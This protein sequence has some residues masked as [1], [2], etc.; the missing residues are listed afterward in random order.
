[1]SKK[2]LSIYDLKKSLK[3]SDS[4]IPHC[5]DIEKLFNFSNKY[6]LKKKTNENNITKNYLKI[7]KK[8]IFH[9]LC[10]ELNKIHNVNY[11]HKYWEIILNP[12]LLLFLDKTFD[13]FKRL[14]KY[15]S[16]NNRKY[17][18]YDYFDKKK[19]IPTN[20]E[21]LQQQTYDTKE[22][23]YQINLELI[24]S[25]YSNRIDCKIKKETKFD[26][27]IKDYYENRSNTYYYK[28]NFNYLLG[29]KNKIVFFKGHFGR[30]NIIILNLK[31]HQLPNYFTIDYKKEI[32]NLNK[33][34]NNSIL[35]FEV[36]NKYEKYLSKN[37][38]THLPT[39]LLEQFNY[40]NNSYHQIMP[41]NP[42]LIF[43]TNNLWW[44][45]LLMFY[46]A[47]MK[48][49][50]KTKLF[51]YQHGFSYGIYESLYTDHEYNISDVF[52]TWGWKNNKK[53]QKLGVN[54]IFSRGKNANK[55]LFV[56]RTNKRFPMN[57]EYNFDE[58]DWIKYIKQLIKIP[59][60]INE[61]LR[62][63]IIYRVHSGNLCNEFQFLKKRINNIEFSDI[64]KPI[65]KSIKESKIVVCTFLDTVF[66]QCLA[67][68]I[69]VLS[70]FNF[71]KFNI[72][73]KNKLMLKNLK[74][75]NVI[76][77]NYENL[78]NH[79]NSKF[80]HIE[81]WWFSDKIQRAIL[82]F[83]NNHAYYEK[84]KNSKIIKSIKYILKN[85]QTKSK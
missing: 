45:T 48:F 2:F 43:N 54:R 26:N 85:D 66:L 37:L 64:N 50:K 60:L 80:D 55:I 42:K 65:D 73:N 78:C 67:S 1:M 14:N 30:K 47:N 27:L 23:D 53:N 18:T 25:L 15:L 71:K 32:I 13:K 76:F 51:T 16:L 83:K 5:Y 8:K 77:D 33:I 49:K 75:H 19:I 61:E 63:N 10:K 34:R 39:F 20:Y 74:K 11:G 81:E 82:K 35:N 3:N 70:F 52:F 7:L 38:F 29:K 40:Y 21:S 69:P 84:K 59:N 22:W 56:H 6:L 36:K 46:T 31:C 79:I 24:K 28:K 12:W 58:F 4:L 44:N 17:F 9:S 72:S 68:N 57:D 41:D 62:R